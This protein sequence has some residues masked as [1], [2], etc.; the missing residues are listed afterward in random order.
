MAVEHGALVAENSW[1]HEVAF[2]T[3]A[4]SEVAKKGMLGRIRS[5]V[6]ATGARLVVP[7]DTL[8]E[9]ADSRGSCA[10]PSNRMTRLASLL[11][12]LGHRAV[13]TM[14]SPS[15]L[16]TERGGALRRTPGMDFAQANDF[17]QRVCE[18]RMPREKPAAYLMKERMRGLDE[19]AKFALIEQGFEA[20]DLNLADLIARLPSFVLD[21]EEAWLR[22]IIRD[23]A[24]ARRVQQNPMAYP[25]AVV[26]SAAHALQAIGVFSTPTRACAPSPLFPAEPDPN[27][28]VDAR[29]FGQSAY[30]SILVVNDKRAMR[31][32]N[33]VRASFGLGPVAMSLDE[34]LCDSASRAA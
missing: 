25:A 16:R 11:R 27:D 2:D 22:H 9:M 32:C 12:Q 5:C 29:I 21:G 1:T 20:S 14:D 24:W 34:W 8:V 26:T 18:G 30:A 6:L 15:M 33:L 23:R 4:L 13:V 10:W 17:M 7:A 28:W 31:R 19:G 3:S